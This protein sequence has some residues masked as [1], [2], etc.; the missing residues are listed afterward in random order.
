MTST[1]TQLQ[2]QSI[3]TQLKNLKSLHLLLLPQVQLH[4]HWVDKT[5]GTTNTRKDALALNR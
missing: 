4:H 1:M 2:Q 3:A 5:T